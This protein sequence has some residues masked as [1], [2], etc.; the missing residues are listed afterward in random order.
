VLHA[1]N[2]QN[3]S[4]FI[5]WI[6][7]T[8]NEYV[9]GLAALARAMAATPDIDLVIRVRTK[10]EVDPDIV[11]ESIPAAPNVT[12]VDTSEDFLAQLADCDLLVSHFST[13]VEQALQMGKPVLLWGSTRRYCQLAASWTP[14]TTGKRAAIY[15]AA[16]EAGLS[17][18]L[19][20]IRE[21]HW[22]QPLLADEVSAYRNSPT[23]PD[24]SGL[25]ATLLKRA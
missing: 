24:V 17:S 6:A 3:W 2:Y 23:D 16:D 5:P 11:R 8:S 18:M 25:A 20:A 13:T 7:E 14:P 4:D 1:G 10:P 22:Q 19:R 15:A 9:A 12:V 21:R